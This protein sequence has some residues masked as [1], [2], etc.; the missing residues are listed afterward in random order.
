MVTSI[1]DEED[2]QPEQLT[3]ETTRLQAFSYSF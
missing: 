3:S 2:A 1:D